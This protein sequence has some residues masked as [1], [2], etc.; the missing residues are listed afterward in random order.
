MKSP[1]SDHIRHIHLTTHSFLIRE[2]L[3][4]AD[5]GLLLLQAR[6]GILLAHIQLALT[7]HREALN[8]TN[9]CNNGTAIP[10]QS[11]AIDLA[12]ESVQPS[13][14]GRGDHAEASSGAGGETVDLAQGLGS[15]SN[16]LDQD[17][18]QRVQD[19]G[20]DVANS[21]TEVDSGVHKRLGEEQ[22]ARDHDVGDRVEDGD[23][24]EEPVNTKLLSGEWEDDGLHEERNDTVHSHDHA[25]CAE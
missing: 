25:Y 17:E 1:R 16:L 20:K 13:G 7:L 5:S 15:G 18:K 12:S 8:S 10:C 3:P 14:N 23:D 21:Q 2:H 4:D 9:D 22:Q 19:D 24:D 6:L 11:R